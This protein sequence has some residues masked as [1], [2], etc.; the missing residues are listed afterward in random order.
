MKLVLVA[1]GI[2]AGLFWFIFLFLLGY[3][4]FLAFLKEWK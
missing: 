2:W 4:S 3:K 1:A